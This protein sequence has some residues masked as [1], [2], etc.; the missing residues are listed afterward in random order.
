MSLGLVGAICFGVLVGW[1]TSRALYRRG[2]LY[3]LSS[4]AGVTAAVGGAAATALLGREMFAWYGVGLFDGFFLRLMLGLT[5]FRESDWLGQAEASARPTATIAR[6]DIRLNIGLGRAIIL[7]N[8]NSLIRTGNLA[9][10][11]VAESAPSPP[12]PS[13]PPEHTTRFANARLR[14]TE[15]DKA[16]DPKA[17]FE[18]G[19]VIRLRLDIGPKSPDSQITAPVAF[20]DEKLPAD[21]DLD[22]MVSST[23]FAVG[24][25]IENVAGTIA[26]GRFFLPGDGGPATTPKGYDFL[27]FFLRAPKQPGPVCARVGYY[28]RNILVQSQL[29]SGAVGKPGGFIIVTD[30]TLSDDLTRLEHYPAQPRISILTNAN[31][32]GTHQIVLRPPGSLPDPAEQQADTFAVSESRLGDLIAALRKI[33]RER[34]PDTRARSKAT[35][36]EDLRQLAPKGYDLWT[37]VPGQKPWIFAPLLKDPASRVIQVCRPTS[38]GFAFPWA[39]IYDIPL[40]IDQPPFCRLVTEWDGKS[41]LVTGAPRQCPHGP[42]AENVLCPFGFWGF[43]YSIDQLSSTGESVFEIAAPP[44]WDFVVGETQYGI[45]KTALAAHVGKLGDVL[46]RRF[47]GASVREGLDKAAIRKLLGR[48]LPL[49]Y[50]YCHGEGRYDG[51]PDTYLGVGMNEPIRASELQGWVQTWLVQSDTRVWDRIRPLVFINACHS[52]E[53]YPKTL[54]SYLDAFVG[55]ARAAGVIGTEVKVAQDLAMQVAERFFDLMLTEGKCV[56]EALRTIRL[57]FLASGNLLGLFYTPYC[58]AELRIA[59]H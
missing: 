26:Q 29:I 30:F 25:S 11:D 6:R 36:Q 20:P 12:P 9:S 27:D 23:D 8:L 15:N 16:L 13:R 31:G 21:I 34:A 47:P 14:D 56:D 5:T 48:D 32:D 41:P 40:N 10:A 4:I 35:L 49:V 42:H 45:D 59:P 19:A 3:A 53:I 57:D 24:T 52:L 46:R 58:W 2:D 50:F 43:R 22:V 55:T 38:S 7:R 37:Q 39:L 28:Y 54:V 51:D 1:V 33:L 17:P 44:T 18:P